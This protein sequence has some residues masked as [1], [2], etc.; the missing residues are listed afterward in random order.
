M[1]RDLYLAALRHKA[2]ALARSLEH[3]AL[4]F[5][6]SLLALVVEQRLLALSKSPAHGKRES[7][8]GFAVGGGH[9]NHAVV[10]KEGQ[11]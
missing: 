3:R 1:T 11:P 2:T 4:G 5:V 10:R 7:T 9:A 6:M 8:P